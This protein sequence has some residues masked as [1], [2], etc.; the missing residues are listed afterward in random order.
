DGGEALHVLADVL[1]REGGGCIARS[2]DSHAVAG[3]PLVG[4]AGLAFL[5]CGACALF[6]RLSFARARP[7]GRRSLRH[8]ALVGRSEIGDEPFTRRIRAQTERLGVRR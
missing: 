6:A 7:F 4:I 2:R 5:A 1:P 8:E 3:P